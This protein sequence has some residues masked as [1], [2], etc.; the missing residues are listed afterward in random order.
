MTLATQTLEVIGIRRKDADTVTVELGPV[1]DA[2]PDAAP[3][4]MVYGSHVIEVAEAQ[5]PALGTAVT[6]TFALQA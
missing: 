2:G 5:M 4:L 1:Q 3:A 6:L